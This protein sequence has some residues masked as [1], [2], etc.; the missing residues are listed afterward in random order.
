MYRICILDDEYLTCLGLEKAVPW[1]TIG[2]EVA[3]TALDGKKGLEL[4]RKEKPDL[5][6]TDI[7][8]PGLT[9]VDL[10]KELKEDGF[11]GEIIVLTAYRDFDYAVETYKSGI[12][13]YLLKPVDNDELLKIVKEAIVKLN[14]KRKEKERKRNR[15]GN[16]SRM[17]SSFFYQLLHNITN[18]EFIQNSKKFEFEVPASGILFLLKKENPEEE[19]NLTEAGNL[20]LSKVREEG[21]NYFVRSGE[22]SYLA[23]IDSK[24][25]EK[26]L[27]IL[28]KSFSLVEEKTDTIFTG[29]ICSYSSPVEISLAYKTDK[30]NI[31]NKMFFGFNSIEIPK[32]NS[33]SYRHYVAIQDFYRILSEHYKDDLSVSMV[34]ERRNVS[35]SSLRHL[36]RKSLGRTF[37]D[38][39]TDYRISLSKKL[40]KEGKLRVNEI[41]DKVGYN[42]EKYF[43]RV[44]KKRVGVSP[45]DYPE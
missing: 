28:R 16:F 17:E 3:F 31:K 18:E 24:E 14:V 23:F 22:A 20:L 4:I 36:L 35:D 2:V 13:S 39:L 19:G 40:L 9:G 15:E 33:I 29:S 10:V 34:S 26:I 32:E 21:V 1:D 6:L 12:F 38:I 44:F 37:N 42:D 41:A 11:D 43:S 8:R 45:S 27:S 5:V 30:D 25:E 7:R